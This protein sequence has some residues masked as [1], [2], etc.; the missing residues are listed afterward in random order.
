[1]VILIDGFCLTKFVRNCNVFV[2]E[3]YACKEEEEDK[4]Y[5][6][7][8]LEEKCKGDQLTSTFLHFSQRS[9]KFVINNEIQKLEENKG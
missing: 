6:M 7:N 3:K 1:V 2:C 4:Q 8:L 9:L 5:H